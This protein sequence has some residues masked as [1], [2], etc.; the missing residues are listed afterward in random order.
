MMN[1][2]VTKFPTGQEK[3]RKRSEGA[4]GEKKLQPEAGTQGQ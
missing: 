3:N 2:V 1:K 4:S